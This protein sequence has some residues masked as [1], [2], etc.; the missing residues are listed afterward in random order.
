MWTEM[1]STT[2][3]LHYG[4][5]TVYTLHHAYFDR[6]WPLD[7]FDSAFNG[8]KYSSSGGDASSAFRPR[9]NQHLGSM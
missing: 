1:W 6:K 8:G 9:E 7:A 5:K 4:L 2:I 3:A